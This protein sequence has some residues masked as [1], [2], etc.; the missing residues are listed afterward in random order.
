MDMSTHAGG[1]IVATPAG[2][3]V[4]PWSGDGFVAATEQLD[5][6][7]PV[8]SVVGEVD[9]A[10]VPALERTLRRATELS[11]REL[12][13]DLTRCSFLDASGLGLLSETRAR[14]AA[15][16]RA[17]AIVLSQPIVL[18]MFQIAGLDKQFLIYPS[19][20]AALQAEAGARV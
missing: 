1:S 14:L 4:A 10:T 15:S 20:G 12:I 17:L 19:L 11:T 6:G 5:S 2:Y 16:N 13:V 7:T 9:L 8:V 3:H 18:K